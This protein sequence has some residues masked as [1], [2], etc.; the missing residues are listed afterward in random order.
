MSMKRRITRSKARFFPSTAV[1]VV[2]RPGGIHQ[3]RD[4]RAGVG[5]QRHQPEISSGRSVRFPRGL[6][7]D[8]SIS[9]G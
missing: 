1:G 4:N 7:I 6:T 5:L 9:Q 8:A 3:R 2:S